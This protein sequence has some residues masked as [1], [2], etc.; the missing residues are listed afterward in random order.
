MHRHFPFY[1]IRSCFWT[2][3][4]NQSL[5]VYGNAEPR[6]PRSETDP[7]FE[8]HLFPER[9]IPLYPYMSTTATKKGN[10][11]NP[12]I[13]GVQ[14]HSK[15][16]EMQEQYSFGSKPRPAPADVT[17]DLARRTARRSWGS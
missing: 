4:R 7:S 13:G 12:V 3:I 2:S 9:E 16:P 5:H 17:A 6:E 15:E 1:H 8:I 14:I 11:R 10:L